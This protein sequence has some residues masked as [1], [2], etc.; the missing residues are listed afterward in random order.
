MKLPIAP[1]DPSRLRVLTIL[2]A[3]TVLVPSPGRAEHDVTDDRENRAGVAD[4]AGTT[5]AFDPGR[6]SFSVRFR[7]E[8]NPYRVFGVFVLPG[9]K[10]PLE[11]VAAAEESRYEVR[12]T[13]GELRSAGRGRWEWTAPTEPGL[14]PIRIQQEAPRDSIRL[15][16]FVMVPF[17]RIDGGYLDGYRIGQYP[18]T[19]LR[20]LPIYRPPRGFVRVTRAN[21]T[22]PVSPHFTLGQFLCKQQSD[23][24]K[25]LVLKERLILKLELILEK[26][27]E[28]GHAANTFFV[29]SGYRT[30]Y[31][32]R[33]IGNVR[34][35]RHVWGDA[36]DVFIDKDPADGMMD[37]LNRDGRIDYRD[38]D[39]LYDLIDS[40][41]AEPG[42]TPF[43]GGL[44]RYRRTPNHG[45]FVHVDS[46]GFRARWGR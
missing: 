1:L 8:T 24:P 25:Y 36:A 44:G 5:S 38:A 37:D 17:D 14:Y 31:Y 11:A 30:P 43:L 23:W 12:P 40:L 41:Y 21:R 29:M 6:A 34:Y 9:E 33:A 13:A 4:T 28:R 46:R 19:P 7:N 15:N 45:P 18:T 27:N 20:Q 39:V 2:A 32:N 42:Y 16:V 26:A 35:S 3:V 22:I 10:L